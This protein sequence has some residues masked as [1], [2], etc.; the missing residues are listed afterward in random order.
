[1]ATDL[2][3]IDMSIDDLLDEIHQ[4]TTQEST[5]AF[6]CLMVRDG[7]EAIAPLVPPRFREDV[8]KVIG[9]L[10][11]VDEIVAWKEPQPNKHRAKFIDWS[12]RLATQ[13]W[14]APTPSV[15]K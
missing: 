11:R 15:S 4:L 10:S 1:M 14:P 9:E 13:G 2:G 5:D 8:E 12:H 6:V 7:F 3:D